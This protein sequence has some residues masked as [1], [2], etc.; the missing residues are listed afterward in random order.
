MFFKNL[1]LD[2][3]PDWILIQYSLNPDPKP[4]HKTV[5]YALFK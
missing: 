5:Q 3:G 4:I 1:S 2:P